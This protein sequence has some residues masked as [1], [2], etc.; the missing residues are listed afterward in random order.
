MSAPDKGQ[1]I[2]SDSARL[3]VLPEVSSPVSSL[4]SLLWTLQQARSKPE[5]ENI[6]IALES[7]FEMAEN[8]V[9]LVPT[10]LGETSVSAMN[11]VL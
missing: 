1:H 3:V 11:K 6:I 9:S 5:E 10:V 2:S 4:Y 7:S 8:V